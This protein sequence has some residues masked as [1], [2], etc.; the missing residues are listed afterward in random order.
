MH[1]GLGSLSNILFSK[2]Q[3]FSVFHPDTSTLTGCLISWVTEVHNSTFRLNHR[4][5]F[6]TKNRTIFVS[7]INFLHTISFKRGRQFY[8]AFGYAFRILLTESCAM[9]NETK[10]VPERLTGVSRRGAIQI[11]LCLYLYLCA[12]CTHTSNCP[13]VAWL[14]YWN[15]RASLSTDTLLVVTHYGWNPGLLGEIHCLSCTR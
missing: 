15:I 12:S 1:D 4:R 5:Y 14:L 2:L 9:I 13:L 8:T 3:L 7:L 6:C 11:H 10:M